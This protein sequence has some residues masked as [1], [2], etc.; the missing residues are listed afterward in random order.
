MR[1]RRQQLLGA[2]IGFADGDAF[3]LQSLEADGLRIEVTVQL[4]RSARGFQRRQNGCDALA[5]AD[6]RKP[7][8]AHISSRGQPT[9]MVLPLMSTSTNSGTPH[10]FCSIGCKVPTL[11]AANDRCH[12]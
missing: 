6:D 10:G 5:K 9:R 8:G 4:E 2:A 7:H 11:A 1:T 3:A 12:P